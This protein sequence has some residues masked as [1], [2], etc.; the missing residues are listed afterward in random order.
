MRPGR[1]NAANS[2]CLWLTDEISVPEWK[3]EKSKMVLV[4]EEA[5]KRTM[6]YVDAAMPDAW[7]RSPY[8]E[9]LQALMRAGLPLGRLVFIDVGGKVSPMLP[10]PDGGAEPAGARGMKWCC[11]WSVTRTASNT[12]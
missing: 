9:R 10:R 4:A 5:R 11:R 8:H 3:P 6:V 12:R 2:P 1:R 7:K